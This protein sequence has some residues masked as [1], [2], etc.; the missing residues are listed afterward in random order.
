SISWTVDTRPD[1]SL[2]GRLTNREVAYLFREAHTNPQPPISPPT[3]PSAELVTFDPARP[4]IHPSNSA[5]LPFDKVTGYIDDALLAMELHTEARTSFITYW[6]PKLSKHTHIALRFLPQNQYEA[7]AP[8]Q[9][10]PAPEITTRVFMLFMGVRESDL[11]AW[12]PAR[13]PAQE[14]SRIVGVDRAKAK[15]AS[16]FRVLEWGGMEIQ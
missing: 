6:L 5:L 4:T 12:V 11:G 1:G 2:F 14:W 10:T 15:D 13:V 16:L 3:T 8:L 9:I 7:S